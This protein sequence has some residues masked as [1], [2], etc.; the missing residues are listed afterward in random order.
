MKLLFFIHTLKGGG[1]ENVLLNI[2]DKLPE[3]IKIT[4][5]VWRKE[6]SG[7]TMLPKNVEL[8]YILKGNELLSSNKIINIIQ[9]LY[10]L[11][12]AYIYW[13][14]PQL[15]RIKIGDNFDRE[16][17]FYH[18]FAEKWNVI[19]KP[20]SVVWVHGMLI[21][22][23]GYQNAE[24]IIKEISKFDEI[25]CVSEAIKN[26][27]S[28]YS[29]KFKSARVIHNP[30]D[31]E[32]IYQKAEEE[33]NFNFS[34]PTFVSV[35]RLIKL[36]GFYPM[37]DIHKRLIDEGY[38]HNIVIVGSGEEEQEMKELVKEK[39]I[40]DTYLMIG[41]KNNPYPY[42][43][44][45][46][47]FFLFSETEGFGLVILEAKLL[48]K[49]I[50]ATNVGGIPEIVENEK[51]AIVINTDN[52]EMY[53]AMKRFLTNNTLPQKLSDNCKKEAEKYNEIKIYEEILEVILGKSSNN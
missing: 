28:R 22:I 32:K 40:Q 39:G 14:F 35:G 44:N 41:H 33:I 30:I 50:I 7:L 2:L 43:K 23:P 18:G 26:H 25:V 10:R 29:E 3:N 27:A 24:F 15:I 5:L 13:K 31:K 52:E 45:G 51:T 34:Y 48:G 42:I 6:G 47:F 19:R 38:L 11:L 36:K 4:L 20:N 21:D 49:P 17:L 9:K 53:Q 46:N 12:L 1:I 37:M 16:I 8:I